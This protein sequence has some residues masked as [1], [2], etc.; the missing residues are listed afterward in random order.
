[1]KNK[2]TNFVRNDNDEIFHDIDEIKKNIFSHLAIVQV[3]T[4]DLKVRY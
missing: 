3:L 1:M 2:K 4:K